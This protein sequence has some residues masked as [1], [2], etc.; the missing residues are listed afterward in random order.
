M[1]KDGQAILAAIINNWLKQLDESSSSP[2]VFISTHFYE[3]FRE[4]DL[5]FKQ[6]ACKLEYLTFD[7]L[8]D[9]EVSVTSGKNT[10]TNNYENFGK[11]IIFLYKLKK[12]LSK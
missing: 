5:L 4:P 12:G 1:A 2:H 6:N 7:Y 8:F 10:A 11:K 3:M 9:D